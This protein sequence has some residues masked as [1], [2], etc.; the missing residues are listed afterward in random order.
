[1]LRWPWQGLQIRETEGTRARVEAERALEESKAQHEE[2]KEV[3]SRLRWLRIRN[4]FQEQIVD[5]IEGGR[6]R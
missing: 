4:H 5:M 6:D 2:A 3:S 1:M